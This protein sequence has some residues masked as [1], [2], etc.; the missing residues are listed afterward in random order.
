MPPPPLTFCYQLWP[1][2]PW[3]GQAGA[4]TTASPW[5]GRMGHCW[6]R[7]KQP[8]VNGGRV[9][10]GE[11]SGGRLAQGGSQQGSSTG[12]GDKRWRSRHGG[13]RWQGSGKG[14]GQGVWESGGRQQRD[15]MVDSRY[16]QRGEAIGG[17]C[18]G[19]KW[20][21]RQT[22]RGKGQQGREGKGQGSGPS[23]SATVPLPQLWGDKFKTTFHWL[24]CIDGK[25]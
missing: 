21:D 16:K 8:K 1:L 20:Q 22:Q 9:A 4:A 19:G 6:S 12:M 24:D 5:P 23:P 17:Q 10:R 11:G 3:P 2:Q 14:M 25:L 15:E 18:G 7:A 13:Q